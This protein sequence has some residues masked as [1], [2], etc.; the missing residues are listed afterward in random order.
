M[1]RLVALLCLLATPGL[2][3]TAAEQA[4]TAYGE[5][6]ASFKAKD[7]A[8]AL[9]HFERAY[10]LDP[11]PILIYNLARAH[12]EMGHAEK[13]I[14]HYE[15]YLVRVPDASD[16]KD[17]EQ[18][19]R[20]MRAIAAQQKPEE[21]PPE[22]KPPEE[23]PPEEKPPEEK[24]PVEQPGVKAEV[25]P[26]GPRLMPILAY[27]SLSLGAAALA[28][29]IVFGVQANTASEEQAASD[30]GAVK[31]DRADEAES[32][33]L[34]A[35]LLYATAGALVGTGLALLLLDPGPSAPTVSVSPEGASLGWSLTF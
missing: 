27:T 9:A 5:G 11:S 29:G 28:T 1:L 22:E 26:A 2:A 32:K 31:K 12:S 19:I 34:A 15:L 30:D 20:V 17:I 18:R 35:N 25:S 6:V 3:Q 23:K 14:E 4:A 16:R 10:K 7:Y 33:A 21:K 8:T 24:P 13:A